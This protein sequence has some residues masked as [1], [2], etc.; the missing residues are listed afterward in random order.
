MSLESAMEI[1]KK[2]KN[3]RW[4]IS[5]IQQAKSTDELQ[6]IIKKSNLSAGQF[7]YF[8]MNTL[9]KGDPEFKKRTQ[10]EGKKRFSKYDLPEKIIDY[11]LE[12]IPESL[13]E[14]TISID[15]KK[16]PQVKIKGN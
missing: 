4:I 16:L 1:F 5:T 3:P 15:L 14:I 6:Q 11:C 7:I 8:R 13:S 12:E 9:Y 2:H 10:D